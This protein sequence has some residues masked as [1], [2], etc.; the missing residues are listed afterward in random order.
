MT[1]LVMSLQAA[2]KWLF[3]AWDDVLRQYRRTLLGPVWVTLTT[4]VL[5]VS[6]SVLW[7]T[8]FRIDL[9]DYLPYFAIGQILFF[10]YSGVINESCTAYLHAES[11]IKQLA[12]PR[13]FFI[14]RTV[15]RNLLLFAHNLP[16]LIGSVLVFRSVDWPGVLVSLLALG[17]VTAGLWGVGLFLAS[18]SARFRDVPFVVANIMQAIFFLSPILWKVDALPSDVRDLLLLNPVAVWIMTVRDPLLGVSLP[19]SVWVALGAWTVVFLALG[20]VTLAFT[21]RRVPYWL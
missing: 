7:S 1:D 20:L 6:L 5:I 4:L 9:A 11:Y 3:L 18:L 2:P 8:I 16:V 14:F 15:T 13:S 21:R 17:A 19:G 10:Y 12:L